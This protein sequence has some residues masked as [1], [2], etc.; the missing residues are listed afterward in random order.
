MKKKERQRLLHETEVM[1]ERT[2]KRGAFTLIELL[3]V[4]AIIAI[5]AAILFPVFAKAREK[6]R[7][8]SCQSNLR[9]LGLGMMM[10]IQD[11]DERFPY[12]TE[13]TQWHCYIA[14][15]GSG[16]RPGI[17]ISWTKTIQPYVK[18]KQLADCPSIVMWFGGVY[19]ANDDEGDY[20]WNCGDGNNRLGGATLSQI[21]EPA[22]TPMAWDGWAGSYHN[23][24]FN[25]LAVDGHVKWFRTGTVPWSWN[26]YNGEAGSTGYMDPKPTSRM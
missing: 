1:L 12:N 6:A 21:K 5:L 7:T 13:Y 9:Q 18:N 25:L 17:S 26:Y 4:I 14:E 23:E 8:A 22:R 20:M 19:A 3:V 15:S 16:R 10:Y 24:G 11:Y 2:R